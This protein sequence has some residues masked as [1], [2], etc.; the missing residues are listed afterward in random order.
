MM[1]SSEQ[2]S[3]LIHQF[4]AS[5]GAIETQDIIPRD[6]EFLLKL[7]KNIS[8]QARQEKKQ[9]E[10]VEKKLTRAEQFKHIVATAGSDQPLTSTYIAKAMRVSLSTVRAVAKAVGYELQRSGRQLSPKSQKALE[11]MRSKKCA[12]MTLTEIS[13]HTGLSFAMTSY[14]AKGLNMK[15]AKRSPSSINAEKLV[16]DYIAN[17][18]DK[19][20]T[21][22]AIAAALKISPVT[23]SK[24][25]RANGI[26][27]TKASP[28]S[29]MAD[30]IL[31]FL[32]STEARTMSAAMIAKRLKTTAAHVRRTAKKI[33]FKILSEQEVRDLTNQ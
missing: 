32:A 14:L 20:L 23:V 29:P 18:G 16:L 8:W 27:L 30:S 22:K 7:D 15:F 31:Q 5:N 13:K 24:H 25:T 2:L 1:V 11:F 12:N 28:A 33:E 17:N 19:E 9:V 6:N 4:E 10:V 26:G 21:P 3:V